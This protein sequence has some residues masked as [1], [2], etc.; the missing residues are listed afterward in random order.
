MMALVHQ[1]EECCS[2][3]E[4]FEVASSKLMVKEIE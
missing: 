2:N 1:F 4:K 3:Q